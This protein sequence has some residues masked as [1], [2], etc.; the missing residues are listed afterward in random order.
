M[1]R[2]LFKL[3]YNRAG[4]T[5]SD[6]AVAAQTRAASPGPR[7]D[8]LQG[9]TTISPSRVERPRG[10]EAEQVKADEVDV[11]EAVLAICRSVNRSATA[12]AVLLTHG[13][14]AFTVRGGMRAWQDAG[15]PV[16]IDH[17]PPN[18]P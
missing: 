17:E 1:S 10:V 16:T 2:V 3:P 18:A 12:A 11:A 6:K 9:R 15:L 7:L 8:G 13:V 14:D 5:D 4:S